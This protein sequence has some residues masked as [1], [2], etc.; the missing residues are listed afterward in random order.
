MATT[1]TLDF[2]LFYVSNLD[3]SLAY[4]TQTLGLE[5]DPKQDSPFFRGFV[6]QE[7]SAGFGLALVSEAA[8]PEPRHPGDV[9]IYF[10]TDN[11]EDRHAELVSKGARP[12]ALTHRPFGSI[13]SVPAPDKQLITLLRPPV[14]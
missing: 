13:F 11:L 4:F 8:S 14:R 3:E 12:T 1:P 6:S 9:E 10:T 5:H 2:V 7:G